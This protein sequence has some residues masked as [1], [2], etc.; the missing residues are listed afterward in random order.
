MK[1]LLKAKDGPIQLKKKIIVVLSFNAQNKIRVI[2]QLTSSQILPATYFFKFYWEIDTTVYFCSLFFHSYP[3]KESFQVPSP[4]C[5][6]PLQ[7]F[8]TADIL[9]ISLCTLC[10][11]VLYILKNTFTH[12]RTNFYPLRGDTAPNENAWFT[13]YLWLIW[14]YT[15]DLSSCDRDYVAL[16]A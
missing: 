15:A 3:C 12:T 14:W 7:N 4:T 2:R 16:K 5:L 11:S 8:N 10:M 9:Y 6:N 13:N 1:D